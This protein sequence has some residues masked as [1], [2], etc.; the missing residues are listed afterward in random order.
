[1]GGISSSTGNNILYGTDGYLTVNGTD[2]GAT[3]GDIVV[4]WSLTQYFP[5]L[6]QARG[7]VSG[8]GIVSEGT[9][10]ITVTLAEFGWANLSAVVGSLGATSSGTSYKFGGSALNDIT[11]V[12]NV[13]VV[14]VSRN[15]GKAFQA[16]ITTAY[17]EVGNMNLSE[18]KESTLE[19]TF[20]GLY[21]TAAPSTLPG[22]VYF[23]K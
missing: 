18:G 12:S 16:V 8:T 17:V 1:M 2:V 13:M 4:E 7:P 21:T 20:H 23:Q 14:G 10:S 11:E 3:E 6:A 9:F 19:V 5:D 22:A 15:D